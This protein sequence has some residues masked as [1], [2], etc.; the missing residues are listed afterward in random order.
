MSHTK[1][2]TVANHKGGCGKT[3][4]VVNL[5]AELGRLNLKVIV[6]DLDPQ[7]NASTHI[8]QTPPATLKYTITELLATGSP[9][10]L[11]ESIQEETNIP[12]VSLIAAN[13][14][15]LAIADGDKLKQL[16]SNPYTVLGS[17]LK[18]LDGVY[19]VI[20]IDTRP[21]M[22][23]L[24][25]N[26]LACSTHFI[27]PL[28]SGSPYSIQGVSDLL[29]FINNVKQ[30]NPGIEMLGLLFNGYN[31]RLKADRYSKEAV[32]QLYGSEVPI[33]PIQIV[34]STSVSF[35]ALQNKAVYQVE[36]N[37]TIAQKY[38]QLAYWVAKNI[39]LKK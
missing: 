36:P 38:K 8:S 17:V 19:D 28:Q 39:G 18:Y 22:D 9:E 15:L 7:G 20:I 26:A 16:H 24:T 5:A 4:T 30:I 10:H 23:T 13:A 6:V 25:V 37:S 32:V 21:S 2:I 34:H 33:I 35:A 1:V 29:P 3:S 11:V 12:N 31:E 14:S 27:V